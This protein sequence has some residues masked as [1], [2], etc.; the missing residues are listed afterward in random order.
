MKE[1]AIIIPSYNAH[2]TIVRTIASI[3]TQTIK[4]KI[5]VYV[6][7]DA[8][9]TDYSYLLKLKDF[10]DIEVIDMETN[11]GCGVARQVG[12]DF[13]KEPF[14]I[15]MDADDTF[16]SA[17]AVEKLHKAI[18]TNDDAVVISGNF[19]EETSDGKFVLHAQDMLWI[20]GKI[21]RRSFL[22]K[23]NVRFNLTRAN[24]D[25]GF[26]YKIKLLENALE[27][28]GYLDEVVHYWHFYKNS[29]VRKNNMEYNYT[30]SIEGTVVNLID[31]YE[32][33][34]KTGNERLG[35]MMTLAFIGMY[36]TYLQYKH[37]NEAWIRKWHTKFYHEVYKHVENAEMERENFAKVT[38]GRLRDISDIVPHITFTQ[39]KELLSE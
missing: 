20:H 21:Y 3:M 7:N 2:T 19:L 38:S 10:L 36:Y 11:G 29:I 34:K 28:I 6:V 39:Y 31:I 9:G 12:A 13:S 15:Y 14:L 22:D 5:K 17:F 32:M 24:E 27:R 33:F 37:L 8:D 23:Y 30:K 35:L 26:N 1:I 18:A 25:M 4:D 16:A